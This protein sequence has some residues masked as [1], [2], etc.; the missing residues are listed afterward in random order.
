MALS[1]LSGRAV[2]NYTSLSEVK[3]IFPIYP[4][5]IKSA[6][7]QSPDSAQFHTGNGWRV[8]EGLDS[9][10]RDAPPGSYGKTGTIV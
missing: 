6:S 7:V 1:I 9:T 4:S 8:G 10:R 5:S 3:E 2:R